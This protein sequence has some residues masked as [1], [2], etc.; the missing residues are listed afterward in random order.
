MSQILAD[1]ILEKQNEIAQEAVKQIYLKQYELIKTYQEIEKSKSV[2]D[3]KYHL[4]YLAESISA[5][6]IPLFLDYID[7]VT[8]IM[9]NIGIDHD[10]FIMNLKIINESIKNLINVKEPE[11]LDEYFKQ[12]YDLIKYQHK[13]PESFL[14]EDSKYYEYAFEYLNSLL[15]ADRRSAS[16]IVMKLH[17]SGKPVKEIYENIFQPVQWEIGRLWQLNEISVAQEHY[18]TAAT[19]L[20]M[21][22]LYPYIFSSQKNGKK[23]MAASVGSELHEIGV[24]MVADFFEIAG[25]DTYYLGANTPKDSIISSIKNIEPD[26]LGLSTTIAYNLSN[27]KELINTIKLNGLNRNTKILVG[28]YPFNAAPELWKRIGADGYAPNADLAINIA[29][30][31]VS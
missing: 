6:S 25:W 17:E 9:E 20:I 1:E 28:G 16:N 27:L 24:R 2:R 15:Q 11:I 12:S 26:V 23:F 19:Q 3:T 31:M 8:V 18:S 14:R 7:W 4:Q 29:E 5:G 13:K 21:S 10:S 22:Q 30:E